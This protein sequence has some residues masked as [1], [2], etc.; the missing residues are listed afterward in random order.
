[1]LINPPFLLLLSSQAVIRGQQQSRWLRSFLSAN[2]RRV[3]NIYLEDDQQLD[4]VYWYLN[5]LYAT[6]VATAPCLTEIKS[7]ERVPFVLD[8]L[9]PEVSESSPI[10]VCL[11]LE[12]MV[13]FLFEWRR[14]LRFKIVL[15]CRPSSML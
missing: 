4:Q 10:H 13:C 3:V 11:L 1:M 15:L 2:R 7:M 5:E 6:A 14:C 12:H 9:L 8:V